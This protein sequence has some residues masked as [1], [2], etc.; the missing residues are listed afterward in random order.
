MFLVF[1]AS[2]CGGGSSNALEF[3][4]VGGSVDGTALPIS[5]GLAFLEPGYLSI[6]MGSR[7][8]YTCDTFTSGAVYANAGTLELVTPVQV[9]VFDIEPSQNYELSAGPG[10]ALFSMTTATCG[11]TQTQVATHGAI[12]VTEVSALGVS[13]AFTVEF[14][15]SYLSI[16]AGRLVGNF[17][18]P[19]CAKSP[20]RQYSPP[21]SCD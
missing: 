15:E 6:N 13:G 14:E 4:S 5:W 9:G 11:P 8:A 16:G 3:T 12:T 20:P 1:V 10:A 7:A 17:H 2:A 18:V 21:T 19:L